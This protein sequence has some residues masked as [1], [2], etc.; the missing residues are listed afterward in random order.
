M[1]RAPFVF[2]KQ[3]LRGFRRSSPLAASDE[4]L[5][6]FLKKFQKGVDKGKKVWYSFITLIRKSVDRKPV[7]VENLAESRRLV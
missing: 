5:L 7:T 1:V 4:D 6:N 2:G 3:I